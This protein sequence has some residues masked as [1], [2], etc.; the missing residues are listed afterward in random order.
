MC[1]VNVLEEEMIEFLTR[2]VKST[3][4]K[5]EDIGILQVITSV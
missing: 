3:M 1:S 4:L 2:N 5:K